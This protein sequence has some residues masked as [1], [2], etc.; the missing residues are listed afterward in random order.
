MKGS[1]EKALNSIKD[2]EE[3]VS[4]LKDEIMVA[5]DLYFERAKKK[6]SLL[7]F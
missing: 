5:S 6:G 7:L 4:S 2:I 3:E 1:H